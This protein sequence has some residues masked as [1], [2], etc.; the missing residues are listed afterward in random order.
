MLFVEDSGGLTSTSRQ[1]LWNVARGRIPTRTDDAWGAF[2]G[3]RRLGIS[4]TNL[5]SVRAKPMLFGH[6]LTTSPASPYRELKSP[7]SQPPSSGGILEGR[8][9]LYANAIQVMSSLEK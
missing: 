5:H 3:S 8:R 4:L 6:H 9:A 7:E 1:H 2:W